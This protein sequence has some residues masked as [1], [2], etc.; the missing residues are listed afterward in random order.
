MYRLGSVSVN[1][2]EL[3]FVVAKE[4]GEILQNAGVEIVIVDNDRKAHSKNFTDAWAKFGIKV[5]PG[6]GKVKDRTLIAESTGEEAEDLGGL[7]VNSPDGMVQDQSVNNTLKNLVGGLYDKFNKR[8]PS[9]QTMA[10]FINDIQTCF[11][12]LSQEKEDS[13][14][15][16]YSAK[17]YGSDYCCGWWSY[18]LHE[19][20]ICKKG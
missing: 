13:E 14:R 19:K 12:N 18:Y 9:R 10:G 2:S 4:F 11:E 15:D 20:W 6:V 7:P 1:S 8:T 5:W 16:R 3:T 17:S